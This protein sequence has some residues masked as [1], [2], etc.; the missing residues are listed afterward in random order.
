MLKRNDIENPSH[1]FRESPI[2][3]QIFQV[4]IAQGLAVKPALRH[5]PQSAERIGF[6]VAP[7]RQGDLQTGGCSGED[8]QQAGCRAQAA[9]EHPSSSPV[10]SAWK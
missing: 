2:A 10:A 7:E 9:E 8:P 3:S 6:F 1:S 5:T 4:V